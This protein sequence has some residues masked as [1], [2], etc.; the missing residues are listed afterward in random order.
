MGQN[1]VL[2]IVVFLLGWLCY[3]KFIGRKRLFFASL[4][5]GLSISVKLVPLLWLPVILAIFDKK[6]KKSLNDNF[7]IFFS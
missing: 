7:K 4:F 2:A 5:F 3:K 6:E 1:D